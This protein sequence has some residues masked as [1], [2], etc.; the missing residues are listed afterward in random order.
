[1]YVE[2]LTPQC[3]L[4][5]FLPEKKGI[6]RIGVNGLRDSNECFLVSSTLCQKPSKKPLRLAEKKEHNEKNGCVKYEFFP[7]SALFIEVIVM[8]L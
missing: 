4:V 8:Q 1:M 3:S 6:F 2:Q 5:S 7:W